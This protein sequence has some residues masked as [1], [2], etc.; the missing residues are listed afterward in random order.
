MKLCLLSD[1]KE[2][3]FKTEIATISVLVYADDMTW[4]AGSKSALQEIIKISEG[5]FKLNN[6]EINRAKSEVIF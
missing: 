4:I 2:N 6:I 5:F 1:I 3:K